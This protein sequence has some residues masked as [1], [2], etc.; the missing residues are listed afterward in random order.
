MKSG[1]FDAEFDP[2]SSTWAII[3]DGLN[4][5]RALAVLLV[6]AGIIWQI[7]EVLL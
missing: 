5:W 6:A 3:A 7:V 4:D 2:T 1:P